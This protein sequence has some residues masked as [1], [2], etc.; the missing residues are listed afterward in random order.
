MKNNLTKG[1][2]ALS[3]ILWSTVNQAT[4]FKITH[5][6]DTTGHH[7]Y[8]FHDIHRD[9]AHQTISRH[10]KKLFLNF[11]KQH[12]AYV[13]AEDGDNYQGSHPELLKYIANE[14]LTNKKLE[15][16]TNSLT[17]ARRDTIGWS[18]A[19]S[20]IIDRT[21]ESGLNGESIEFRKCWH[22]FENGFAITQRDYIVELEDAIK[23]VSSFKYPI[24][25]KYKETIQHY[26]KHIVDDAQ[27]QLTSLKAF[28]QTSDLSTFDF[29]YKIMDK[30]LYPIVDAIAI[31]GI[32]KTKINKQT[33][34][35]WT[36]GVHAQEIE[37]F[38]LTVGYAPASSVG[39]LLPSIEHLNR[40]GSSEQHPEEAA[41]LH[42]AAT[43]FEQ[44]EASDSS[45]KDTAEHKAKTAPRT[46]P[47]S[48]SAITLASTHLKKC[49]ACSQEENPS[50]KLLRCG[51]C[52][53]TYYCSAP[54]Q[55]TD[56]KNHKLLCKTI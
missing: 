11:A 43:I 44:F 42:K 40:W 2:L 53:T 37:K 16:A 5:F 51:G 32:Y 49:S 19:L 8:L 21:K 47:V 1:L 31:M 14:K 24:E 46:V 48:T 12:K 30:K 34:C 18:S 41:F 3:C 33:S 17:G 7:V 36:G 27:Q 23:Q 54:C 20:E 29:M 28:A 45:K 56:W 25:D 52:K 15:E 26:F 35:V 22:A 39:A 9:F 55:K 4:I 6:A 13:I 38:L 10:H 50:T